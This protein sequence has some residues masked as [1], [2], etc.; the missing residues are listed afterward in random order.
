MIEVLKQTLESLKR[1]RVFVTTR[2]KIEYPEVTDWYNNSIADL[3]T[4]IAEAEKRA[5]ARAT[6][7]SMIDTSAKR[8]PLTQERIESGRRASWGFDSDYFTAG[9]RFAEAAHRIEEKNT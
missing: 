1:S 7:D 8:R 2:E 6:V 9:V 3:R 5:A 4:A